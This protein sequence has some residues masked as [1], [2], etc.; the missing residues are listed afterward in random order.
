MRRA[1]HSGARVVSAVFVFAI[2][3]ICSFAQNAS[4]CPPFPA[5]SSITQ[6]QDLFSEHGVLRVN[7][8][9]E[10][11]VDQNGNALFCFM[12]DSGAESPTLHVRPGDQLLI[13]L[14]NN[15]P[16]SAS[17]MSMAGMPA[18]MPGMSVSRP[19]SSGCGAVTM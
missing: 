5:G 6:P 2:V 1:L 17:T 16:A 9:Y 19:P 7:L 3:Q 18:A 12:T 11:T 8:T 13:N 14:K 10:T 4:A 15:V